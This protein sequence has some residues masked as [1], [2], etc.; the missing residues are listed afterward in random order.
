MS[1]I[2]PY[3]QRPPFYRPHGRGAKA[4]YDEL[5]ALPSAIHDYD[6]PNG[7]YQ[8]RIAGR[9]MVNFRDSGLKQK[10]LEADKKRVKNP[11]SEQMSFMELDARTNLDGVLGSKRTVC[12]ASAMP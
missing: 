12:V 5:A 4:K 8:L 2:G 1:C 3:A 6:G 7:T 9:K 11:S 10:D